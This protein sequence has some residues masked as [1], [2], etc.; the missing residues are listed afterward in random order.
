MTWIRALHVL[1]VVTWVGNLFALTRLLATYPKLSKEAQKPVLELCQKMSRFIG[2]PT[3]CGA[4]T[5]GMILIADVNFGYK[6]GWFHMKLTFILVMII[7]ELMAG[8]FVAS[9][10]EGI[11]FGNALRAKLVHIFSGIALIGIISSLYIVRDREGEVL[12]RHQKAAA[13]G[14]ITLGKKKLMD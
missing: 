8:R 11:S 10:S 13:K 1:C 14:Q 3:M 12:D 5:F 6:P 2:F 9:L 7:C 4:V